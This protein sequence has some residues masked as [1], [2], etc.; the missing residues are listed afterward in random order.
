MSLHILCE[1]SVQL[2]SKSR[3]NLMDFFFFFWIPQACLQAEQGE[4]K[5]MC[6]ISRDK[7]FRAGP[8][9]DSQSV[10][11]VSLHTQVCARTYQQQFPKTAGVRGRWLLFPTPGHGELTLS[12]WLHIPTLSLQCVSAS[13]T[14]AV[15]TTQ[16]ALAGSLHVSQPLCLYITVGPATSPILLQEVCKN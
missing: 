3:A 11:G 15:M 7:D 5:R 10:E 14:T 6:P 13:N 8:S 4:D 12:L 9:G 1:S 16:P 2:W